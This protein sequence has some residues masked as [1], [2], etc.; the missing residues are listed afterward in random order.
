MARVGIVDTSF[1]RFN[2]GRSAREEIR[3]LAGGITILQRTVPG[4]KDLPVACKKLIEEEECEMVMALGMPGPK[5]IDKQCAHEAS[6]GLIAAQLLTNTHI[7]EVF[8]HEDEAKSDKELGWLADQRA[9][10]HARNLITLLLKPDLLRKRAGTGQR[11][12]F[13]DAGPVK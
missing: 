6:L 3:Q 12:G 4:V 9:R 8:V 2:M 13:P 1:A 5:P 7:L 10:E 11:E